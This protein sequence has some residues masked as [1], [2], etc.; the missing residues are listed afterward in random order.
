MVMALPSEVYRNCSAG[1]NRR[2][3]KKRWYGSRS[4]RRRG[5]VFTEGKRFHVC[6]IDLC[7]QLIE[8]MVV[9]FILRLIDNSER[10]KRERERE[11]I[12]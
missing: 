6:L 8:D 2:E 7:A 12:V 3:R 4:E 5:K 11:E 1:T 10:R 9:S